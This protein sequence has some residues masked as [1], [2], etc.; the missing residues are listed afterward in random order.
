MS[1]KHDLFSP[2]KSAEALSSHFDLNDKK[3]KSI[4]LPTQV[5]D[6]KHKMSMFDIVEESMENLRQAVAR[7]D[8]ELRDMI[9]SQHDEDSDE[10]LDGE[11]SKYK[12]VA[13]SAFASPSALASKLGKRGGTAS[14]SCS[15][16][17]ASSSRR[18]KGQYRNDPNATK[19]LKEISSATSVRSGQSVTS[20]HD[21]AA[22]EL[23]EDV[24]VSPTFF[25]DDGCAVL[26]SFPN[27]IQEKAVAECDNMTNE[28]Q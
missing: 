8:D 13:R 25:D 11:Y 28:S 15:R 17:G 2:K 26:S 14:A 20:L 4:P 12:T 23:T 27:D 9:L 18:I 6:Q 24:E 19:I 3:D 10:E 21:I 7:F 1:Y 22:P 16:S 5:R